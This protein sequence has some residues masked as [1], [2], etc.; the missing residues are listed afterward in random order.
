M[1]AV[2]DSGLYG[3]FLI[4]SFRHDAGL[5]TAFVDRWRPETHTFHLPF[6]EAT[7]TMEDVHYILGLSTAGRPVIHNFGSPS[8]DELRVMVQDVLG[9]FSEADE[10]HE[11]GLKISWMVGQFATCHRLNIHSPDYD[12]QLIFHIRAHLLLIIASLFPCYTGNTIQFHL[13]HF[14]RD[15]REVGTYSWGSFALAYFT[16]TCVLPAP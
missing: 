9:I 5:I 6:G 12:M 8:R 16:T 2:R 1:A 11:S 13:L 7:I 3:V 15:H 10:W 14:V 4:G